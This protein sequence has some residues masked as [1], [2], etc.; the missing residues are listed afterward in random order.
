MACFD[1]FRTSE[2]R[3]FF[4]PKVSVANFLYDFPSQQFCKWWDTSHDPWPDLKPSH[5]PTR[6]KSLPF[7]DFLNHSPAGETSKHFRSRIHYCLWHLWLSTCYLHHDWFILVLSLPNSENQRIG[8]FTALFFWQVLSHRSIVAFHS[9][10]A[11]WLW[12]NPIYIPST[13]FYNWMIQKPPWLCKHLRIFGKNSHPE[14]IKMAS[15]H[16]TS[17]INFSR[18]LRLGDGPK[19]AWPRDFSRLRGGDY[20]LLIPDF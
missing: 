10:G 15:R 8:S 20:W 2:T 4:D 6:R 16:S 12:E 11:G 3:S 14:P 18:S 17:S 9:Q 19:R 13:I 7:S 1:W 5:V